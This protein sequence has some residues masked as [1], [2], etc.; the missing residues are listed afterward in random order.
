MY[1]EIEHTADIAYEII[2]N[3]TL[4]VFRDIVSIIK[5]NT[6]Y[7]AKKS[8]EQKKHLHKKLEKCYN[9]INEDTGEFDED[10]LFDAVNGI[11]SLVD[12]GYYPYETGGYCI[13]Y[14]ESRIYTELKALTYYNL[15]IENVDNQLYVRMVFDV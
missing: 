14:I 15:K 4:E 13:S 6:H 12:R 8:S 2:A 5:D 10:K 7:L 11:I 9:I 1:R 3:D